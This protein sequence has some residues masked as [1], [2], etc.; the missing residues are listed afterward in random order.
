MCRVTVVVDVLPFES[1]AVIATVSV[2]V[3]RFAQAMSALKSPT[4]CSR[5]VSGPI[6]NARLAPPFRR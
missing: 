6:V 5:F 2:P 4:S 1:T 3:A